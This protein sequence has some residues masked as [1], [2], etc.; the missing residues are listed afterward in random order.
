MITLPTSEMSDVG[1]RANSSRKTFAKH[2]FGAPVV[3]DPPKGRVRI[4]MIL[5]M[6]KYVTINARTAQP[7]V[8]QAVDFPA[9]SSARLGTHCQTR[10]ATHALKPKMSVLM[11]IRVIPRSNIN[12]A[13]TAKMIS[14]ALPRLS[15]E[16]RSDGIGK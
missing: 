3:A 14:P 12:P 16:I 9:Q 7:F 15:W 10:K 6:I 4:L 1:T 5:R 2:D 8:T 11:T 13:Q